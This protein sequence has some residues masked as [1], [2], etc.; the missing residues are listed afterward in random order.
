M[1]GSFVIACGDLIRERLGHIAT[2]ATALDQPQR[3]RIMNSGG[4][5]RTARKRLTL[6]V[7]V[8]CAQSRDSTDMGAATTLTWGVIVC[9]ALV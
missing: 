6:R 1:V 8:R 2:L 5:R 7:E 9:D 4:G 3:K